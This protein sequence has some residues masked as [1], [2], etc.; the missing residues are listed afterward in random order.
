MSVKKSIEIKL[1]G[2]RMSGE[3]LINHW[4]GGQG[5][6]RMTPHVFFR[7]TLP[8]KKEIAKYINDGQF[9]CESIES[10]EVELEAVYGS[11]YILYQHTYNFKKEEIPMNV[12]RGI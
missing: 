5:Y 12:K 9:G 4:G 8:S 11:G 2:F 6:I 1:S 7:Q 10:A 3:A